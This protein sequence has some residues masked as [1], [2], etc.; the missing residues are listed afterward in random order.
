[1]RPG[2]AEPAAVTAELAL[3]HDLLSRDLVTEV[4]ARLRSAADPVLF[5]LLSAAMSWDPAPWCPANF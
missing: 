3:W 5:Q 1:V 2:L 4:T